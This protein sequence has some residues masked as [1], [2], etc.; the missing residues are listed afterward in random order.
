[1]QAIF[2]NG[3]LAKKV[4]TSKLNI[5]PTA[6]KQTKKDQYQEENIQRRCLP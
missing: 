3:G 4:T 2:R 1:M 6:I 5:Y